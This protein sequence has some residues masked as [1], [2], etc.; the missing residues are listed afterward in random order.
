MSNLLYLLE[1]TKE[2]PFTGNNETDLEKISTVLAYV[3]LEW[4][5]SYRYIL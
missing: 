5:V 3:S 1:K 4:R 2:F